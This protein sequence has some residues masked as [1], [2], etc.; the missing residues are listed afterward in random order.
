[1]AN[2]LTE[3]QKLILKAIIDEYID[4]AE[5]VGSDTLD[6][7][8]N[9][10]VSPA[11]IRNEMADL[12]KE[13]WLLK[14]HTSSG[15]APT[16]MALKYYVKSLMKEK[17]MSVSDEVKVKEQVNDVKDELDKFMREATRA[18]AERTK[19]I[20]LTSLNTGDT[21]YAGTGNILD[22]PEFFDI[23]VTK[24]LLS[25]LD[26]DEYWG[27]LIEKAIETDEP[28]H[29]LLGS[30]LGTKYLAPCGFVYTNFKIGPKIKGAIGVVGPMRLQYTTIIP[31]VRYF[32]D[33]I[34]EIEGRW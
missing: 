13:G 25:L 11:T 33:L 28:I 7:K 20:A 6:K 18:L 2:Q 30:D 17:E 29:L 22:M 4:T 32:G 14:P 19:T 10:G 23:D 26:Q 9:L 5:A 27:Q 16:P 3:R 24:T 21:Y 31:T 8:Y 34:T 1:M 12:E 15:R